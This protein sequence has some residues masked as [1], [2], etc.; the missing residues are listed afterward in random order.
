MIEKSH[1][2]GL[3]SKHMDGKRQLAEVFKAEEEIRSQQRHL[4][5]QRGHSYSE[6]MAKSLNKTS[7]F[8]EWLRS[9]QWR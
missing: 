2:A 5:T 8:P 7:P 3:L 9:M 6:V 4:C 1:Q